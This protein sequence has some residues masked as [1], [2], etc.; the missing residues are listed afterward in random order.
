MDS[1]ANQKVPGG[2]DV[3]LESTGFCHQ[4]QV[5][6]PTFHITPC[7]PGQVTWALGFSLA[8]Y[9]MG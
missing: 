5:Q 7:G 2:G 6:I 1:D 4:T 8:I 9:K 3:G